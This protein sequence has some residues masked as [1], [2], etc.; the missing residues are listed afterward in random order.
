MTALLLA[1]LTDRAFQL[2]WPEHT[3][4]LRTPHIDATG[5]LPALGRAPP[6]EVRRV[7]WI[8]GDR[9]KLAKL[10]ASDELD[11]LWPERVV[12]RV[13]VRVRVTHAEQLWLPNPNPNLT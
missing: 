6:A 13:R 5:L 8:N 9:L 4:A 3:T 10:T 11:R 7:M 1:I 12:L 2:D